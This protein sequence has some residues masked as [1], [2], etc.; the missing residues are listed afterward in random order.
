VIEVFALEIDLRAAELLAPALRVIDR[1]R[2]ADEVRQLVG[3]LGL[4]RRVFA[5]CA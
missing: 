5:K 3:E 4:E 2:P 1:T